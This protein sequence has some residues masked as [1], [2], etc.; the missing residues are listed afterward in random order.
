MGITLYEFLVYMLF[1]RIVNVIYMV[2][3]CIIVLYGQYLNF[4]NKKNMILNEW[5]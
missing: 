3:K 2:I 4:F 1:V 5:L